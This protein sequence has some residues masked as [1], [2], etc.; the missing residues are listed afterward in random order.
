MPSDTPE[1]AP[2]LP[3]DENGV[4]VHPLE[5]LKQE[6]EKKQERR[7]KEVVHCPE[8]GTELLKDDIEDA[9]ETAEKHDESRHDGER[10]TTVNG[11]LLP[12]DDVVE[13]AE[14]ALSKLRKAEETQ[15]SE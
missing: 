15:E 13:A 6:A 3:T 12:S 5:K 14:D 11:M 7:E 2:T 4:P 1:D 10:T 9:V 8:C